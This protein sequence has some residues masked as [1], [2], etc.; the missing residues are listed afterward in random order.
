MVAQKHKKAERGRMRRVAALVGTSYGYGR[1]ILTGIAAYVEAHEPWEFV[2]DVAGQVSAESIRRHLDA[3]GIITQIRNEQ[4]CELLEGAGVPCVIVATPPGVHQLPTVVSDGEA[5]GRMAG[6][7][8]ADQGFRRLAFYGSLGQVWGSRRVK[9]LQAVAAERGFRCAVL[10]ADL[11]VHAEGWKEDLEPLVAWVKSLERPV[12]ILAQTDV[13]AR[14]V[15]L[16]CTE[17]GIRVPDEVA[18]VGVD[19]DELVCRL[20]W[21]PLTSVDHGAHRIGWEAARLLAG[22]MEG[23]K[24]PGAPVVVKPTGVVVRQSSDVLAV[25]DATVAAALRF[26]R[27]HVS[28]GVSVQDVL[29]EVATAR[30]TLEVRFRKLLGRSIHEEIVRTQVSTAKR[31]LSGTELPMPA[32]AAACG[33]KHQSHLSALFAKHA[34]MTPTGYRRAFGRGAG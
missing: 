33:L 12:G 19:N 20:S 21:P 31:L 6:E 23:E 3:D 1:A 32:V 16:A 26:I 4:D 15:L 34:G 8:L 9:G 28:R 13:G 18:I 22:L 5:I 10:D 14:Q 30:R 2:F 27:T 24:P 7:H 25:E 11:R 29:E 17:A